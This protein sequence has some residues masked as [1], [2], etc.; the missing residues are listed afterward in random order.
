MSRKRKKQTRTSTRKT[1][2]PPQELILAEKGM[3]SRLFSKASLP[4][5]RN[6]K[7]LAK[8]K[9]QQGMEQKMETAFSRMHHELYQ[10][11]HKM[12]LRL[13]EVT[14]QNQQLKKRRKFLLPML[15][16][17]AIG[18]GYMLFVLTNMQNS[19]ANMTGDISAMNGHMQDMSG[20]TES[21]NNSMQTLNENVDGMNGNVK[22][23]S[24]S[25]QPIGE[26]AKTATPFT[27]AF[28]SLIPF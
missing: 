3:I 6:K 2:T 19:M 10:R 24:D 8:L 14:L 12:E 22:Q 17:A 25:I 18:G 4:S 15:F 27:K 26:V 20:N 13:Q 21:M 28:R 16:A 7:S 11:E 5:L 9:H 23:M 1:T